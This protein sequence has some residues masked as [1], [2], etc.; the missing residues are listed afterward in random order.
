MSVQRIDIAK[1]Y[2][3]E[4]QEIKNRLKY[5]EN[6]HIYELTKSPQ[7]GSLS[8]NI[9]KLRKQLNDLFSK[10]ENQAPSDFEK[11]DELFE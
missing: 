6:G 4:I 2:D 7:D 8:T 1:D 9:Q 10:I 5:L 3:F 11:M